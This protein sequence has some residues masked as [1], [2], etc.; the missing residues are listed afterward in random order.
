MRRILAVLVCVVV[1]AFDL[2]AL[3][4]AAQHPS[5]AYGF[6]EPPPAAG[7]HH[8]R[9]SSGSGRSRTCSCP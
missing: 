7:R 4:A 5:W 8:P 6:V 9:G 1:S 3:Y 2:A